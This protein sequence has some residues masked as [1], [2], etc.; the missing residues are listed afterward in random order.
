VNNYEHKASKSKGVGRPDGATGE[1]DNTSIQIH[2]VRSSGKRRSRGRL[3][4]N[5][6]GREATWG[7]PRE[8]ARKRKERKEMT[9]G[10]TI[11]RTS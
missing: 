9:L 1:E 6:R 3:E 10:R 8:E 11:C 4:L 2:G 5:R 7:A